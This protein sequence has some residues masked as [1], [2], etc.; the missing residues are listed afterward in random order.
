MGNPACSWEA[1]LGG[2][3]RAGGPGAAQ[4]MKELVAQTQAPSVFALTHTLAHPAHTGHGPH[5]WWE[6]I[7]H[8]MIETYLLI[9]QVILASGLLSDGSSHSLSY[10]RFRKS[11]SLMKEGDKLVLNHFQKRAAEWNYSGSWL[12]SSGEEITALN[13]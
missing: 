12:W 6:V 9:N 2:R 5:S 4:D 3:V 10:V 8:L 13:L 7:G 11:M 1:Q